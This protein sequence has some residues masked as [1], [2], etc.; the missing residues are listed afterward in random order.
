M[1]SRVSCFSQLLGRTEPSRSFLFVD[2]ACLNFF[3]LCGT[4][5]N[6][7]ICVGLASMFAVKLVGPID[8][9]QTL[10]EYLGAGLFPMCSR[11]LDLKGPATMM[12]E[13]SLGDEE[14]GASPYVVAPASSAHVRTMVQ[15]SCTNSVLS[16]ARKVSLRGAIPG[17]PNRLHWLAPRSPGWLGMVRSLAAVLQV[18]GGNPC[19]FPHPS[20][21][22]SSL[23]SLGARI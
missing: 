21:A 10:L 17:L 14:G 9:A 23:A 6:I 5:R 20:A 12:I 16:R 22:G 13:T 3:S 4:R 19:L 8:K 1:L 15:Y 2:I 18:A 7:V 11:L